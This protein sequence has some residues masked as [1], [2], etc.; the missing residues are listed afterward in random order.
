MHHGPGLEC[1]SRSDWLEGLNMALER[2]EGLGSVP[3]GPGRSRSL[4]IGGSIG[5]G[6]QTRL[7]PRM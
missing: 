4:E 7:G 5:R 6:G 1:G 2:H 3:S